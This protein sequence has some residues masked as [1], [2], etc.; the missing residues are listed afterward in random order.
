MTK[1]EFLTCLHQW[2][3]TNGEI[4]IDI[5][6]H[7]S[8]SSGTLYLLKTADQ[9]DSIIE[10]TLSQAEHTGDGLATIT[11]FSLNFYPLRGIVDEP[12]IDKIRSSWDGERDFSIVTF[13]DV[14]PKPI[15]NIGTGYTHKELEEELTEMLLYF[16]DD[17]ICFGEHPFDLS[18][19]AERS[20]AEV[21][22]ITIGTLK[23]F[24][25]A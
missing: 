24:R 22:E 23:Q 18:D 9:I 7:H 10:F 2:L 5:Y 21:I 16:K 13:E 6:F 19:W 14:F 12:F 8:G 1:Q 4:L 25:V 3:K 11:A 17:F 15:R 20:G